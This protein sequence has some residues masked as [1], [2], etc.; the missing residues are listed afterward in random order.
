MHIIQ[1]KLHKC[2]YYCHIIQH[3]DKKIISEPVDGARLTEDEVL[4]VTM[5]T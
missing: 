2:I 5:E 4:R 3:S 1:S